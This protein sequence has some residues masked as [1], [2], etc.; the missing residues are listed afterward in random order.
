MRSP[1]VVA[2]VLPNTQVRSKELT[3]N[4]TK[5]VNIWARVSWECGIIRGEG[6]NPASKV[7]NLNRLGPLHP[8]GSGILWANR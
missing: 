4:Y 8:E 5:S 2:V 7:R 1:R 6:C 3:I